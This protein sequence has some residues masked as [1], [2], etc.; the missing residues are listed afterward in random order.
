MYS[1][2]P[3]ICFHFDV[4]T[5]T[6]TILT[7]WLSNLAKYSQLRNNTYILN[8]NKPHRF[9]KRWEKPL[10]IQIIRWSFRILQSEAAY[11]FWTFNNERFQE[12]LSITIQYSVLSLLDGEWFCNQYYLSWKWISSLS[13]KINQT[14]I[15]KTDFT[16]L[17]RQL[18]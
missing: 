14:K 9:W 15:P 17:G 8:N 18:N 7:Q 3:T 1:L 4:S 2:W 12:L 5:M 10:K 6:P 16:G 13:L 11:K